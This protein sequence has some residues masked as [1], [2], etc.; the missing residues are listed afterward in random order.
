MA[1][2]T[3]NPLTGETEKQFEELSDGALEQKLALSVKAFREKRSGTLALRKAAMLKTAELLEA[4]KRQHAATM[5]REMGKPFA[6]AVAEAEKCARACRHYAEHAESY[7]TSRPLKTDLTESYIRYLPL[8]P[9]LAVMP[10]NFPYWQV[11]RFAAPALMAGNVGLLKHASNV[12]Q[13]ALAIEDL[14]RRAGFAEGVFQTLLVGSSKVKR[15][16]EDERIVAVTLTGSSGAGAQVASEAGRKIKKTVLELGGSDPFIVMPSAD[17]DGAAKVAVQA[18]NI[19]NGQSCIAAKRFIVHKDI[20]AAFEAKFIEHMKKLKVGDPMKEDTDIGPLATKQGVQDVE[21]QVKDSVAMGAKVAFASQ[22]PKGN[23]YFYPPTLLTEVPVKSPAWQEELFGPV[24]VMKA[25]RDLDEAIALA[26]DTPY[27]LGSAAW[28]NDPKEEA[29]FIDEL[30]AGATFI[31]AM[32]A[33]DPR[34]PFGGV[35][36]SG[37]GR[38]LADLGMHEFMNAKT[39]NINRTKKHAESKSE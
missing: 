6:A 13:C 12:P 1:I 35:K 32:V 2:A 8:G 9:V 7:L 14:F 30:E 38:E 33:S 22:T 29:R 19:N 16:I 20:A 4:E 24:A 15:I 3:T 39:V 27:G 18:R 34:Q 31:N 11:F 17:L 28:T 36:Q 26:N 37:Y 23:G 21:K 25:A 10:W 5:V